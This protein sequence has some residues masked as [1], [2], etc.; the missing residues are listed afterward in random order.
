MEVLHRTCPYALVVIRDNN[1][2]AVAVT[3]LQHCFNLKVA[4]TTTGKQWQRKFD[5]S[6][7]GAVA[8][9]IDAG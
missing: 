2:L 5:T 8:T 4:A 6:M 9:R 3:V 1:P 7:L